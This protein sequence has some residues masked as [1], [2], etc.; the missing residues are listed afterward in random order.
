MTL[1]ESR[2]IDAISYSPDGKMLA[3]AGWGGLKLWD[4]PKGV[5]RSELEKDKGFMSIAFSR[6]GKTLAAGS[7]H[8]DVVVWNL[9]RLTKRVFPVSL[10]GSN[11]YTDVCVTLTPDARTLAARA[12]DATSI[13]RSWDLVNGQENPPLKTGSRAGCIRFSPGGD[14]LA[15]AGEFGRVIEIWNW[16]EKRLQRTFSGHRYRITSLDFSPDGGLLASASNDETVKLW[17]MQAR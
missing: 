7:Y 12:Y 3:S 8:G 11:V 15:V 14:L 2:R 5:I 16:Q 1:S 6:D 17:R 13:V 10:T 9:E 4:V